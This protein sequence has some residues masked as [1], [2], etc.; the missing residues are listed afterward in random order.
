MRT[1]VTLPYASLQLLSARIPADILNC[2]G[3]HS[4]ILNC[5]MEDIYVGLTIVWH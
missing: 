5:L 2:I 3:V 1:V 4:G